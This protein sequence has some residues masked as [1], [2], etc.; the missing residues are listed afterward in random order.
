MKIYIWK[1][2]IS[3]EKFSDTKNLFRVIDI[4]TKTAFGSKKTSW[5]IKLGVKM[6]NSQILVL[7]TLRKYCNACNFATKRD[8]LDPIDFL[9]LPTRFCIFSKK[10]RAICSKKNWNFFSHLSKSILDN[11]VY[12]Y[13]NMW[14]SHFSS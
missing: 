5:N 3:Q 13:L 10:N 6:W 4:H 9:L 14:S 1:F 7:S 11:Q 12:L 8:F 2:R